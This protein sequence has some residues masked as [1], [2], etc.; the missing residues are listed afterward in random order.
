VLADSLGARV[1]VDAARRIWTGDDPKGLWMLIVA[2]L[3]MIVNL[4]VLRLLQRYRQGEIQLRASWLFTRA[5]VV[6]NG[7]V[8]A[9][10][11]LVVA[12]GSRYPDVIIGMAI[13]LYVIRESFEI[14]RET[15]GG[16]SDESP[17]RRLLLLRAENVRKLLRPRCYTTKS[18]GAV[19][20]D[21]A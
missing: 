9:A 11:I 21:P 8:I 5:D 19:Q 2:G 7:G 16:V 20:N 15:R 13:G 3:A 6:A 12:I 4:V 14:L 10:G 1:L 17:D 18:S